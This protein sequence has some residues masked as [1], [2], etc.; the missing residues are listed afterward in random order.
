M[1]KYGS[2]ILACFLHQFIIFLL[3]KVQFWSVRAGT[4][5]SLKSIHFIDKIKLILQPRVIN[6]ITHLTD[7]GAVG[8]G[9]AGV[10]VVVFTDLVNDIGVSPRPALHGS[11]I[12]PL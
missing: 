10:E 11:R 12:Q 2:Q 1:R 8:A 9:G 3:E 7:V 5:I 4:A 6:S